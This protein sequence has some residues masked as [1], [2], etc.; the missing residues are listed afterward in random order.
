MSVEESQ[1]EWV[2]Y[3]SN[4]SEEQV[5]A[6]KKFYDMGKSVLHCGGDGNTIYLGPVTSHNLRGCYGCLI[7]ALKKRGGVTVTP[8]LPAKQVLDRPRAAFLGAS[9]QDLI[10]DR[11]AQ[12]ANVNWMRCYDLVNGVGQ[13]LSVVKESGCPICK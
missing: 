1:A 2:V 6:G 10:S 12:F 13:R 4:S 9:I 3:V 5:A 11:L 7:E 8:H